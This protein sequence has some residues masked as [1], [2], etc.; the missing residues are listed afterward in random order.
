MT[1]DGNAGAY[2]GLAKVYNGGELLNMT[3]SV[4]VVYMSLE[5]DV[6]LAH[7]ISQQIEISWPIVVSLTRILRNTNRYQH[8]VSLYTNSIARRRI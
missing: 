2:L 8:L 7:G 3:Q 1:I 5:R 4:R 6:G